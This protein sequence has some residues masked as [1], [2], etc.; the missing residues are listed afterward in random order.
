MGDSTRQDRNQTFR[1][2]DSG[3]QQI[4]AGFVHSLFLKQDGSLWGMGENGG[5][6]LGLGDS[7]DRLSPVEIIE[8]E[9]VDVQARVTT[10]TFLRPMA[11]SGEWD[12]TMKDS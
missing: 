11:L 7:N 9:V 5:G 1:I 4:A 12:I 6:Q 10:L 2:V 8:G 3:V